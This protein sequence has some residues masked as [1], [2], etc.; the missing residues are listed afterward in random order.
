M[1]WEDGGPQMS[2]TLLP[3]RHDVF[4]EIFRADGPDVEDYPALGG[5]F[6]VGTDVSP[7]PS[8]LQIVI[9]VS[10]ICNDSKTTITCNICNWLK[11]HG[12]CPFM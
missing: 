3:R 1:E 6:E 7:R 10:I 8:H 11:Q 12:R 4:R 2:S 5:S 9:K